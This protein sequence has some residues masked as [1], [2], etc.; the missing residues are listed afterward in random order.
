M[1]RLYRNFSLFHR[2]TCGEGRRF[3]GAGSV[4]QFGTTEYEEYMSDPDQGVAKLYEEQTITCK[5]SGQWVPPPIFDDCVCKFNSNYIDQ[6]FFNT[7]F[8]NLRLFAVL[9]LI[10]PVPFLHY[11]SL[12]FTASIGIPS[13]HSFIIILVSGSLAF[14]FTSPEVDF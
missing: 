4:P 5:W 8:L 12:E 7:F 2:Y 14:S 13:S 1:H 3:Y 6:C 9:V 10:I 11:H